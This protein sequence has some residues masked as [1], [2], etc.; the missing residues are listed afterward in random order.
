MSLHDDA[1]YIRRKLEIAV[2]MGAPTHLLE[3]Y[4]HELSALEKAIYHQASNQRNNM[5]PMSYPIFSASGSLSGSGSVGGNNS[6]SIGDRVVCFTGA[7]ASNIVGTVIAFDNAYIGIEFDSRPPGGGHNL[8]GVISTMNGLWIQPHELQINNNN[9]VSPSATAPGMIRQG[10]RVYLMRVKDT[11]LCRYSNDESLPIYGRDGNYIAGIIQEKRGSV[12]IIHWDNGHKNHI[13]Q[14]GAEI[15]LVSDVEAKG[16]KKKNVK[17]DT[18]HLD[19]LVIKKE[20]K[21]EILSVLKQHQHVD[22]LFEEWGLGAVIEYGRGMTFCFWGGPGT[23]KTWAAHCIAKALG[24]ELLV[25]AA[26]DIQSSE[27]GGANRAITEAFANAKKTGKVLFLDE[28]DSLIAPRN[29]VGMILSS[30]INTLLTEIEKFEGVAILATNR[31]GMMDAALERRIALTIEFPDPDHAA[32][33]EIWERMLPE[34]MPRHKDIT[35]DALAPHKLTGGQIK[36][37]LLQAARLA[38]AEESKQVE[39]AHFERAIDRVHKS[40]GLMGKGSDGHF[41]A[42]AQVGRAPAVGMDK[43]MADDY[44]VEKV[45]DTKKE[46]VGA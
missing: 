36:N 13:D 46:K 40:K 29:E 18:V 44:E 10:S 8:S 31:V 16:K 4:R 12:Y 22:K 28:C 41:R 42:G 20:A 23:G 11:N 5:P 33:K 19:R 35:P 32:R 38:L 1:E 39:M 34:K 25:I 2:K 37:V 26:G 30:E 9:N 21:D 27:P 45:K 24:T 3:R 43:V 17:L 7:Y 14:R 6:F 15:E